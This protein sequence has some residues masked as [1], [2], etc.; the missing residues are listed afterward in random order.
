LPVSLIATQQSI[1]QSARRGEWPHLCQD[2][3]FRY[4]LLAT[5]DPV[6]E[7]L[8]KK[9]PIL[10]EDGLRLFDLGEALPGKTGPCLLRH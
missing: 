8:Q 3:G 10:E 4:V 6:P 1:E 7:A 5:T 2:L 9:K